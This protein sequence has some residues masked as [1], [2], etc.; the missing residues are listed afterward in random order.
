MKYEKVILDFVTKA[1]GQKYIEIPSLGT[2]CVALT[3]YYTD[4]CFDL[5]KTYS[6][7]GAKNYWHWFRSIP[8]LEENFIQVAPKD[9]E[10]GDIVI[11]DWGVS[12]DKDPRYWGHCAVFLSTKRKEG[13][14]AFEVLQQ[15]GSVDV[16]RDGA[17]DGVA[18]TIIWQSMLGVLGGLRPKVVLEEQSKAQKKIREAVLAA[19]TEK[20]VSKPVQKQSRP[21]EP[22]IRVE[23]E[24]L[25]PNTT[26]YL[27]SDE[28]KKDKQKTIDILFANLIETTAEYSAGKR[29]DKQQRI[30]KVILGI[31]LIHQ[32]L[33]R[34][35]MDVDNHL[36]LVTFGSDEVLILEVLVVGAFAWVFAYVQAFLFERY[37]RGKENPSV[38]LSKF[39][40]LFS[41]A[42]QDARKSK[43]KVAELELKLVQKD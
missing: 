29:T 37:V 27:A 39:C 23:K 10:F 42:A 38:L 4:T 1:V 28:G 40:K 13:E 16:N 6:I 21:P 2:Q 3:A 5:P 18:H 36:S 9:L 20:K 24:P 34:L 35:I 17:A 22:E 31:P 19:K 33:T 8:A 25:F 26:Q 30:V 32:M 7:S 43:K 15:D 12:N 11:W 41:S 14:E